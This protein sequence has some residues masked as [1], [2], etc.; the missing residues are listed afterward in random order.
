MENAS[1]IT[2]E[3]A[4]FSYDMNHGN[5]ALSKL[6][7]DEKFSNNLSKTMTNLQTSTKGLSDNMEAAKHNILLR[8]FFNKKKREEEKK[9]EEAEK[10]KQEAIEAAKDKK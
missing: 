9:K 3:L 6:M 8:G 1:V 2:E 4:Q 5:G 10:A 7:T